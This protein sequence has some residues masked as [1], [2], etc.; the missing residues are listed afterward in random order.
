MSIVAHRLTAQRLLE[1]L[2]TA[3]EVVRHFGAI[4][5]QDYK[6]AL[7]G[8]GLRLGQSTVSEVEKSIQ[9]KQIVRTWAMRGTIHFVLA[10]DV[11]WLLR[12]FATKQNQ[13]FLDTH[14]TNI[15]LSVQL[16]E[17]ARHLLQHELHGRTLTRPEIYA[18]FKA[19]GIPHSNNWGYYILLYW[20]QAG[21]ICFAA[22]QDK[23]ATYALL[24]D[25]IPPVISRELTPIQ[26]LSEQALRYFS[27]HGMAT[28]QDF[29]WWAGITATEAKLAL[30]M[31][32]EQVVSQVYEGKTYWVSVE[33]Q[34][35]QAHETVGHLLPPFDEYTVA[36]KDRSAILGDVKPR[37]GNL[38]PN[39]L[40][41]GKVIGFWKRSEKI[42]KKVIQITLLT[43]RELTKTERNI[44]EQ[45][46]ERYTLFFE[47]HPEISFSRI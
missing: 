33:Y 18:I 39:L 9:E 1:P 43:S 7:W 41:N 2:E 21:Y 35:M 25:W 20:A 28:I 40:L 22:H 27:S 47:K 42:N 19:A 38:G 15:G 3:T 8:I 36:F 34:N 12:R 32:S 10:E 5:A 30:E 31:I 37:N 44:F 46:A 13:V 16:L 45:S 24:D 17:Q 23:Q 4:Q 11:R 6:A 29:A 14:L 26:A